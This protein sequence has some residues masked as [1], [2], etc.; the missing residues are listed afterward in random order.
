M[1]AAVGRGRHTVLAIWLLVCCLLGAGRAGKRK[2]DD[3]SK[4]VKMPRHSFAAPLDY[5]SLLDDWMVS[6]SSLFER[7]RLLMHAGVTD[8]SGFAWSKL[9]LLTSNFEVIFHFRFAGS[10]NLGEVPEDQALAFWYVEQNVSDVFNENKA[11]QAGSWSNGLL[12]Q[13]FGFVGSRSSFKGVGAVLTMVD[14]GNAK[15]TMISGIWND[16]SQEKDFQKDLPTMDAK[17]FDFRNTLNAV[18]MRIRFT[19]DSVQGYVKQSPS[20][21]WQ[22][23]FKI[24]PGRTGTP[25]PPGGY[26]GFTSKSGAKGVPDLVSIVE[27]EVNNF[28]ENSIGEEMKDVTSK[29][30]DAY[31]EM[32]TDDTRHFIDQKSQT[33]HLARLTTLIRDHIASSGPEE[34]K[35]W[36]ELGSLDR[37]IMRLDRECATLV[38]EARLLGGPADSQKGHAEVV[39]SLKSDIVGIRTLLQRDST[40]YKQKMDNFQRVAG[41]VKAKVGQ[42]KGSEAMVTIE[43]QAASLSETVS[44]R[45]TQMS[46]MLFVLLAAIVVIGFLMWNRMNYYE[47]KQTAALKNEAAKEGQTKEMSKKSAVKMRERINMTTQFYVDSVRDINEGDMMSGVKPF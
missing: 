5:S 37:R 23:C 8:R 7:Q 20:L 38:K 41:D 33:D 26:I 32:L 17:S 6:G 10:N 25:S 43:K 13:G 12:D 22:E 2:A 39:S 47:K 27:V 3:E 34:D 1:A 18:Q 24:K 40:S 44:S 15:K 29:I 46:R 9:P 36:Q 16:G 11:I 45:G 14:A 30:Q 19:D 35:L 21:S 42:T 31:K 4:S 28:D